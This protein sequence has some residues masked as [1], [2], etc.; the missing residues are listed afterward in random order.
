[1]PHLADRWQL[2]RN[3]E[4]VHP[5][6]SCAPWMRVGLAHAWLPAVRRGV[7]VTGRRL[8]L[9]PYG[10]QPVSYDGQGLV[11]SSTAYSGLR[12][13]NGSNLSSLPPQAQWRYP[14]L[15]LW[16]GELLVAPGYYAPNLVQ[17]F[18]T[19]GDDQY[20][21]GIQVSFN[22]LIGTY[23][24][25]TFYE[26]A[27]GTWALN[28]TYVIVQ[29]IT[30]TAMTLF[31][32][33]AQVGTTQ[34]GTYTAPTLAASVAQLTF[35]AYAGWQQGQGTRTRYVALYQREFSDDA[36]RRLSRDPLAGWRPRA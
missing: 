4:R 18:N 2:P 35:G 31:V 30:P 3:P 6:R 10:T 13:G 7:D 26:V 21:C 15:L 1:M 34:S 23:N 28:R 36:V 20:V 32:D 5:L 29:R 11:L 24:N 33:G 25:G 17:L 19:N 9:V 16:V 22:N 14:L 12:C 8:D 27:F